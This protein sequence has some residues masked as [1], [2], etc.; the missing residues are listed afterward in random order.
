MYPD[1]TFPGAFPF[2]MP[3]QGSENNSH[4]CAAA[5]WNFPY[6]GNN[7]SQYGAIQRP[8]TVPLPIQGCDINTFH[9]VSNGMQP[10][11][12]T[13]GRG[14]TV[15][16]MVANCVPSTSSGPNQNCAANA[17]A[18]SNV[19]EGS[20][21]PGD[22]AVSDGLGCKNLDT[23]IVSKV[24]SLLSDLSILQNALYPE[25]KNETPLPSENADAEKKIACEQAS[26]IEEIVKAMLKVVGPSRSK[27]D[28]PPPPMQMKKSDT[29]R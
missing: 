16:Q 3:Y 12:L 5:D 14:P 4:L 15:S 17:V 7:V 13:A 20:D 8:T 2:G 26:T 19:P 23:D 25:I 6:H 24:S 27:A 29:V 9:P 21:H 22:S 28:T 1:G 18:S 11:A 10:L